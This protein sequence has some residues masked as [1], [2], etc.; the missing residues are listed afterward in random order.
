VRVQQIFQT[1]TKVYAY[2]RVFQLV[3]DHGSKAK[4]A[5]TRQLSL[6]E[7]GGILKRSGMGACHPA[8]DCPVIASMISDKD[9]GVRKSALT[10]LRFVSF[11]SDIYLLIHAGCSVK[12]TCLRGRKFGLLLGLLPLRTKLNSKRDCDV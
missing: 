4:V 5:K 12:S 1:L 9:P 2:S 11:N 6:D 10:T 8:K 3:L 7:L